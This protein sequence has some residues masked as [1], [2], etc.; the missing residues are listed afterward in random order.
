VVNTDGLSTVTIG[1]A[2]NADIFYKYLNKIEPIHAVIVFDG[3]NAQVNNNV[4]KESTK[5]EYGSTFEIEGLCFCYLNSIL[6]IWCRLG[7]FRVA[8]RKERIRAKNI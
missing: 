4:S 7:S 8:L 2:Y 6:V 3:R 1:S 5:L